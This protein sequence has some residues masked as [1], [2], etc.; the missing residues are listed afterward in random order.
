M[1][2]LRLRDT[3]EVRVADVRLRWQQGKY[4]QR[5]Y[6]PGHREQA[7]ICGAHPTDFRFESP[8][9][10]PYEPVCGELLIL[11]EIGNSPH[12]SSSLSIGR[13]VLVHEAAVGIAAHHVDV[14]TGGKVGGLARADFEIDRHRT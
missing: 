5:S 14:G 6:P 4:D 3:N 10:A 7:A 2:E 8:M 12:T 9:A 11:G 13:A 1:F